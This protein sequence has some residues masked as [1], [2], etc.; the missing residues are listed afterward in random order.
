[1]Q[2]ASRTLICHLRK[3]HKRGI[4]VN[5]ACKV[6]F[7]IKGIRPRTWWE[8]E[9]AKRSMTIYIMVW[10]LTLILLVLVIFGRNGVIR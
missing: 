5:L 3:R 4:G 1:M 6:V 2:G 9:R 10:L 7:L 8:K